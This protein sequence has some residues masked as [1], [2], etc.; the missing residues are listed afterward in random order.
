MKKTIFGA[1]IAAIALV[2]C[3]KDISNPPARPVNSTTKT[4]HFSIAQAK[5]YSDPRYDG[6]EA[7][8]DIHVVKVSNKDGSTTAVWDTA[9]ARQ[10][11]R[12]FPSA[13]LP[14]SF[15]K[16][17]S[18]IKDEEETLS[19]SYWISYRDSQN[20][21][22]GMGENDFAPQGNSSFNFHVRL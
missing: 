22:S 21:Q 6:A 1:A 8:L 19:L 10:S 5:D 14:F 7:S 3:E 12:A 13:Q 17:F 9:I 15:R 4:I 16:T 20:Q 11:I 18:G 2:S